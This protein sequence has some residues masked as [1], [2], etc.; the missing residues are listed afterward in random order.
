MMTTNRKTP[1]ILTFR[2]KLLIALFIAILLF[3]L[4]MDSAESQ[5]EPVYVEHVVMAGES[6]WG[7]AGQYDTG[8]S[9]QEAVY[10]IQEDNDTGPLIYPGQV[11]RVRVAP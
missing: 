3:V 8:M 10:W 4:I 2:T 9:R 11:L 7:I 1:Q 6:L 5:G